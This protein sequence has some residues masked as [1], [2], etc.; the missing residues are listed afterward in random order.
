MFYLKQ[1][2]NTLLKFDI[3]TDNL[4]GQKILSLTTADG[5][6][7]R[8]MPIG[9]NANPES[10]MKW[11]KSRIIPKNREF[12]YSFLEKNG[13][14]HNDIKGILQ[15]SKGLSL[16]DSYWI[17]EDDN[18][19]FED[20]NLYEHDFLKALSL[21]AY[22]GNG[23][24][25]A[26]GF[27]SSPEF[28]TSGMLR[29]GW[30][31]LNG[32]ILLYKGGTSGASNAGNEPYSEY[33]A[34]QIARKMELNHVD[35]SLARWKGCICSVCELFTDIDHSYVP[36]YRFVKDYSLRT[37]SDYIRSLGKDYYDKFVDMLIFDALIYNED[38]HFG[39]FGL[40]VD[41][42]TNMPCSFAPLFD[43][44]LSLFNYATDE[45][46]KNIE[47]YAKTRSSAYGVPFEN[48]I[49]EFIAPRHKEQ[50]RKMF[51]FRFERDRNYNLPAKRL[52]II[53]KQ[54]QRRVIEML[55]M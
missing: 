45:K 22:T 7:E 31:R 35:Y 13:L 9:V 36:I 54:L 3:V 18:E 39:N 2:N 1:Y 53:E 14:S 28:T 52:R 24:S 27:I 15:T 55:E 41:N 6:D 37:V 29:K 4:D 38:R 30:R 44:G 16:N 17:V 11:L 20:Y 40:I 51:G 47:E 43:N 23:S 5:F 42:K 46:L 8:K 10:V 49:K 21:L 48:I 34:S 33:Y 12:V 19:R 25:P 32:K 26:K 50:L